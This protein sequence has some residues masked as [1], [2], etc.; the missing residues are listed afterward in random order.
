[1]VEPRRAGMAAGPTTSRPPAR[2]TRIAAAGCVRTNMQTDWASRPRSIKLDQRLRA[3]M[4]D[5]DGSL[6]AKLAARCR[7]EWMICM[8]LGHMAE[9]AA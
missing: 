9:P 3:Q 1:M 6:V 8:P 4:A 7:A 2:T 5:M